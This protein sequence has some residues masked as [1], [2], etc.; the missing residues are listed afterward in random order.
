MKKN[1][2]IIGTGY[3]GLSTAAILAN[4]G[5]K[6]WTVDVDPVKI[7]TIKKG[8]SYFFEIGMDEFV[9][10]GVESG[11]LIPTL[12]HKNAISQA[13]I[14]FCCV[15]T[16][17][18]PNGK[19]NLEYVFQVAEDVAKYGEDNLI[20]VQKST[21]PVGTARKIINKIRSL[22]PNLKFSYVSNPE[23]LREG[24]AVYDTL[25]ID[26]LV[27]GGEDENAIKIVADVFSDVDKFSKTID[28][29]RYEQYAK[30]YVTSSD[31]S[32]VPF[33]QKLVK[34]SIE[35][36]ELIKVTANAFLALKISF[37]NS[38]ALLCS[39]TNAN[40]N[41]VMDGVGLDRRISRSFLHAGLGWGGGC[42]PKDVSGLLSTFDDANLSN[43]I[44]EGAV[45]VN[46]LMPK[47]VVETILKFNKKKIAVLGLSFKPGTSDVRKSQ[48]IKLANELV[49]EGFGVY[50]YDPKANDE[51]K[52]DLDKSVT[53]CSSIHDAIADAEVIV[54]ATEWDEFKDADWG[55]L[56]NYTKAR[57]FVDGRNV[58]NSKQ[59]RALGYDYYGIGVS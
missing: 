3:V 38:I 44:L 30:T 42:F 24:S 5:Y 1:I 57:I 20:F 49:Q 52:K 56:I 8:S 21:V 28:L 11:N 32:M 9:R 55:E 33:D 23:F 12:D 41:E 25:N 39:K 7:D 40:V 53:I 37:A 36:A 54:L 35:S 45:K 51:A 14:V 59:M 2:A 13:D 19:P 29:S 4:V 10:Q 18:L 34:T 16:P 50:A 6:V 15:G 43:P 27:I 31:S 58:L 26:R 17:D 47:F 46:D 22:N 48:S